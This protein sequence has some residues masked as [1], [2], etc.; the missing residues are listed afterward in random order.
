MEFIVEE[1][2]RDGEIE[3]EREITGGGGGGVEVERDGQWGHHIDIRNTRRLRT[4]F[5]PSLVLLFLRKEAS[6]L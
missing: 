4:A 6:K 1:I 5:F 3:R 2:V